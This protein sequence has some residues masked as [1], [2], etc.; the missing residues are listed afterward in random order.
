[1][2]LPRICNCG[3][4][5]LAFEVNAM[6]AVMKTVRRQQLS[7]LLELLLVRSYDPLGG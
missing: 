2:R 3:I 6:N 7:L 5:V 1:M 4:L